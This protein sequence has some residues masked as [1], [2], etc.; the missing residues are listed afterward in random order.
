LEIVT[1][2]LGNIARGRSVVFISC[3]IK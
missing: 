1:R 3:N 2:S